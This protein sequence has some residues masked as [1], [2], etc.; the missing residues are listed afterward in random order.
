[1][2]VTPWDMTHWLDL[3]DPVGSDPPRSPWWLWVL[4][5]PWAGKGQGA[6]GF[7]ACS[8]KPSFASLSW[9]CPASLE[10]WWRHHHLLLRLVMKVPPPITQ[11]GE[12][13]SDAECGTSWPQG[14]WCSH[15]TPELQVP[16]AQERPHQAAVTVYLA[17]VA[18]GSP[19]QEFTGSQNSVLGQ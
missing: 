2:L 18:S 16:T 17:M 15:C 14:C 1:M 9:C 11:A 6:W 8:P 7:F 19:A 12:S 13:L 4:E 5:H 3:D 10:T